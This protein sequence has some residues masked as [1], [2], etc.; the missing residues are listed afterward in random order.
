MLR[1]PKLIQTNK[2]ENSV[3]NSWREPRAAW[4]AKLE[5]ANK[6]ISEIYSIMGTFDESKAYAVR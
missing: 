6:H 3:D 1:L 2:A 4:W 5:R